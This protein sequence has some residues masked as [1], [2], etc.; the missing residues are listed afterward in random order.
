MKSLG[1]SAVLNVI[2]FRNT[3]SLTIYDAAFK[4]P[5]TASQRSGWPFQHQ[6]F[7]INRT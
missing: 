6:A 2:I 4:V 1:I 5:V 3:P 7:E